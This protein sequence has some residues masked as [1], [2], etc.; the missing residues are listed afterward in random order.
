M[1]RNEFVC[2]SMNILYA[3]DW[4]TNSKR[5][6][7]VNTLTLL[8]NGDDDDDDN[9]FELTSFIADVRYNIII[10]IINVRT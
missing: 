10:I 9:T 5:T 8:H 2:R 7:I 1:S 4:C 3:H 6:L